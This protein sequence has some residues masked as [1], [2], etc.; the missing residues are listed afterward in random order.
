MVVLP[1]QLIPG[2]TMGCLQER[3]RVRMQDAAASSSKRAGQSLL[4]LM[5]ITGHYKPRRS[6]VHTFGSLLQRSSTP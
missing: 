4:K 6:C 1:G 2:V 5:N 3:M